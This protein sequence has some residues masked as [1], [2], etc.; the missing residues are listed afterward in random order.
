MG[1][2]EITIDVYRIDSDKARSS[3]A[4]EPV[5]SCCQ[6]LF[7]KF[8]SRI[9]VGISAAGWMRNLSLFPAICATAFQGSSGS[10]WSLDSGR[11][12]EFMV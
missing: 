2:V 3:C 10:Y 1:S 5:A 12:V 9:S 8:S 7:S 11:T 4:I 6:N